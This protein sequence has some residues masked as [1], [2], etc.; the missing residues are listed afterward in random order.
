LKMSPWIS[1]SND[2]SG[3]KIRYANRMRFVHFLNTRV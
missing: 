3:E 2:L 1:F